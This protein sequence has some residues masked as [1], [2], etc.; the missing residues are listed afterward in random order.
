MKISK[1]INYSTDRC[2]S[3]SSS[4]KTWCNQDPLP[5]AIITW[6]HSS[7]LYPIS[8]LLIDKPNHCRQMPL[9]RL[10]GHKYYLHQNDKWIVGHPIFV[11]LLK[12]HTN[13]VNC[14]C[15]L[16]NNLKNVSCECNE[17]CIEFIL[18]I[19]CWK[20]ILLK[21]SKDCIFFFSQFFFFEIF[22]FQ[23]IS[24]FLLII[25]FVSKL[26]LGAIVL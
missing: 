16:V 3:W 22:F 19:L 18:K 8:S 25:Y 9:S 4:S 23:K 6:R 24:T 20:W 17:E 2:R 10:A 26:P 21:I 13:I 7:V 11:W 14:V 5:Y 1:L 15:C 12:C